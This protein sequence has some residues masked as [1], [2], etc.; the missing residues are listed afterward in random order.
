MSVD[1]ATLFPL[2]DCP[3]P[4]MK[5]VAMMKERG[6]LTHYCDHPE[7]EPWMAIFPMDDEEGDKTSIA[8]IMAT[9]CRLYDEAGLIAYGQTEPAALEALAVI[10]KIKL[11]N[12]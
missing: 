12:Q 2:P 3:S 8:D 1:N 7:Q 9:S 11:W 6:A 5:W 10:H 4:R